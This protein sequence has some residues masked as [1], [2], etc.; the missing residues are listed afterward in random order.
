MAEAAQS[1]VLARF[2]NATVMDQIENF[3]TEA[4]A[5]TD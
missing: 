2:N 5:Q 1:E 3:L 4:Q